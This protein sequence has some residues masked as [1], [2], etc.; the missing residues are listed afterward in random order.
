MR[1]TTGR[2][3]QRRTSRR[4]PS[5]YSSWTPRRSRT[6]TCRTAARMTLMTVP[7]LRVLHA[8]PVTHG[9]T[10]KVMASTVGA[11]VTKAAAVRAERLP[12]GQ[13][14]P[15]DASSS[16][17]GEIDSDDTSLVPHCAGWGVQN[18][19]TGPISEGFQCRFGP[20]QLRTEVDESPDVSEANMG[21]CA[22]VQ[23]QGHCTFAT[24]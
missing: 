18:G 2:T 23:G 4:T 9:D 5:R 8:R 7:V 15:P 10:G 21:P 6:P 13:S 22:K 11:G 19:A 20:F 12:V 16:C 24:P 17:R 1:A 14:L 3:H